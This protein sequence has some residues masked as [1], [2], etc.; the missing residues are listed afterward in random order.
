[1]TELTLIFVF[2][3]SGIL[4][5]LVLARLSGTGAPLGAVRRIESALERAAA[6]FLARVLARLA[7]VSVAA[8]LVVAA[9]GSVVLKS[10]TGAF[11]AFGVIFGA[12][13]AAGAAFLAAL[14]LRYFGS[15]RAVES[16]CAKPRSPQR[17]QW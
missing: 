13:L 1:M 9:V 11:G 16:S 15:G 7:L 12:V 3:A 4:L 8:A 10:A 6:T 5:S 17:A 14:T 2:Q